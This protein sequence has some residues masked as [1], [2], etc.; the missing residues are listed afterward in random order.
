ML[1]IHKLADGAEGFYDNDAKKLL[2]WVNETYGRYFLLQMVFE[3]IAKPYVDNNGK[4]RFKFTEDA[5]KLLGDFDLE[6]RA[7]AKNAF[8][9]PV[10]PKKEV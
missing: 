2:D 10:K 1:L 7:E 5:D 8:V 6:K 3:G 4:V 9:T